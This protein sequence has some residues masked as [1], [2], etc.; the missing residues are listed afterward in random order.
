MIGGAHRNDSDATFDSLSQHSY[1]KLISINPTQI[2]Y[3]CFAKQ[4]IW[5][6]VQL[7]KRGF[8]SQAARS[9]SEHGCYRQ[10][11]YARYLAIM[12]ASMIFRWFISFKV[13]QEVSPPLLPFGMI[14]NGYIVTVSDF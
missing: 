7:D 11:Y 10:R 2:I 5:M 12:E 4:D 1:F 6:N 14:G 8:F 3:E 9:V 13:K